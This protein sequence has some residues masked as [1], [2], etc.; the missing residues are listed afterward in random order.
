MISI[1]LLFYI[2]AFL[3]SLEDVTRLDV[4]PRYICNDQSPT[5][6]GVM[7]YKV[8]LYFVSHVIVIGLLYLDGY[9]YKI[10]IIFLN[11]LKNI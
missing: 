9:R 11:V 4:I 3:F 6:W 2:S 10:I 8:T 5:F 7:R 1:V